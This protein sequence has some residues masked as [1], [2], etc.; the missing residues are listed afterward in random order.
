M[1]KLS[2][3]HF[4]LFA[5]LSLLLNCEKVRENNKITSNTQIEKLVPIEIA[6]DLDEIISSDTLKIL[7]RNN[8]LTYFLYRGEERGFEFELINKFAEELGVNVKIVI[9]PNWDDL[10]PYLKEGKG[11]VIA[12]SMTLTEERE[13]LL[14]FS[15]PYNFVHQVVLTKKNDFGIEKIEDLAGKR[16]HVINGSSYHHQ[17]L[18]I[19]KDF[20]LRGIEPN[21][22]IEIIDKEH[23]KGNESLVKLL[24]DGQIEI[25]VLDNNIA[26]AEQTFYPD[27]HIGIP[28]SEEQEVAWAVRKKSPK[29]LEELNKFHKDIYRSEF[30]NILKKRYY[31]KPKIVSRY[32]KAFYAFSNDNKISKYDEL[33]QKYSEDYGF[34]WVLIASQMYEESGFKPSAKSWAGAVGLMQIM[35]RTARG[36]GFDEEHSLEQNIEIGVKH[37]RE[38]YELFDNADSEN[39]LRLALAAYNVGQG[40]VRD[41]QSLAIWDGKDSNDW[42]VVSDYLKKLSRKEFYSKVKY[43]YCR[44]WQTVLYVNTILQRYETYSNLINLNPEFT[45]SNPEPVKAT[46]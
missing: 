14:K 41:A 9:P 29:L 24:L 36:Y 4:I 30:F 44:G 33:I 38:L 46:E 7:T 26:E 27:L 2:P 11:D 34:D 3:Q 40:H 21:I 15:K 35:P 20:T 31:H 17:L 42:E 10:I 28:L 12:C 1:R 19:Q 18:T 5:I 8:I 37:L 43:G 32:K 6:R 13:K 39:R 22:Q 45:E 23:L 25:T 16:I